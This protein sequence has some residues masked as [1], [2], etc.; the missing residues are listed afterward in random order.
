[1]PTPDAELERKLAARRD[2]IDSSVLLVA[3]GISRVS[4]EQAPTAVV[5]PSAGSDHLRVQFR[6]LPFSDFDE[7]SCHSSV[8][9]PHRAVVASHLQ[10]AGTRTSHDRH[11]HIPRGAVCFW[12]LQFFFG[13]VP[14]SRGASRGCFIGRDSDRS[15]DVPSGSWCNVTGCEPLPASRLGHLSNLYCYSSRS[16]RPRW[17]WEQHH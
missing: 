14:C 12:V 17:K 15:P 7:F 9:R 6:I 11:P 2:K 5:S 1:M 8:H 10:R 13:L 3:A 4:V 16:A